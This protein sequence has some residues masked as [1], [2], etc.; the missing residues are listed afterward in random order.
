MMTSTS[1][2]LQIRT[3]VLLAIMGGAVVLSRA[4]EQVPA[5]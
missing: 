4:Q 3:L 2:T 1:K 5:P